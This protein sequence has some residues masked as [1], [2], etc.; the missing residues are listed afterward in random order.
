[1]TTGKT[2]I[3]TKVYDED[4]DIC[5]HMSKHD[6][7]TFESYPEIGYQEAS[8]DSI[9]S[10]GNDPTKVRIYQCLERYCLSPTY[11]IDLP[12]YL[13]LSKKGDYIG[14]LQGALT[15]Q[16]IRDGVKSMLTTPSE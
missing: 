6:R 15:I 12:V 4:C 8:L 14:H 1:M 7:A 3:A 5:R 10:H 13:L 9:I 2:L 16:E 11:E